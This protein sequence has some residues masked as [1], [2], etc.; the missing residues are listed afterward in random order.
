MLLFFANDDYCEFMA[1][2]RMIGVCKQYG[3]PFHSL[4][5]VDQFIRWSWLVVGCRVL[6]HYVGVDLNFS[7]NS[8]IIYNAHFR[9][10]IVGRTWAGMMKDFCT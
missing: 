2:S 5:R 9:S 4:R 3:L 6:D 10:N 1:G 8:V 7:F